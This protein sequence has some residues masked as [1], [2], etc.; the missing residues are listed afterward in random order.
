MS[1]SLVLLLAC[2]LSIGG[3]EKI[4]DYAQGALFSKCISV[5][6]WEGKTLDDDITLSD[7]DANGCCPDGTVPGVKHKNKYVNAQV[8]CGFQADGSLAALARTTANSVT[9]CTYNSCYVWKQNLTCAN[10]ERQRL[11]GCCA[12][13]SACAQHACGFEAGCKNYAYSMGAAAQSTESEYCATYNTNYEERYTTATDDDQN[14]TD[15]TLQLDKVRQ[16]TPCMGGITWPVI[17]TTKMTFTN[18]EQG[19]KFDKCIKIEDWS[20]KT[21][22]DEVD[23]AERYANGCC[24]DGFTPGVTHK[25]NYVNAQVVCGFKADGTVAASSSTSNGVKTCTYNQC[26][27]WKQNL[28]CASGNGKQR[29][30]GCCAA[31]A[32]CSG[33]SCGFKTG[34]KNYASSKNMGTVNTN[35]A[36]DYCSTYD[37]NYK[38]EKTSGKTDDQANDKLQIDKVYQYTKCAGGDVSSPTPA[39]TPAPATPAP[40]TASASSA[41]LIA[42]GMASMVIVALAIF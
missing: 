12:A 2:C 24:P 37:T 29:L 15:N 30:N 19:A 4:G 23:V 17:A 27:V 41:H 9:T 10:N 1:Q 8:V 20:S 13:A 36:T 32:D 3:A 14:A 16:F 40:G 39:P 6:D 22:S 11:N 26:Y 42:L 38:M 34:C 5:A 35:G 18:S 21:L 31:P 28:E 25:A 33:N 7:R